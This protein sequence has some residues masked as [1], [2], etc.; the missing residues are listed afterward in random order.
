VHLT[1]YVIKSSSTCAIHN[2]CVQ[3]I[4]VHVFETTMHCVRLIFK[5]YNISN[6]IFDY[7]HKISNSISNKRMLNPVASW[8]GNIVFNI[9]WLPCHHI[10]NINQ[11]TTC[12]HQYTLFALLPDIVVTTSTV[13]ETTPRTT[14]STAAIETKVKYAANI[15]LPPEPIPDN[16][17]CHTRLSRYRTKMRN[18]AFGTKRITSHILI[19]QHKPM[20]YIMQ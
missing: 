4:Y 17:L 7:M 16:I 12:L 1:C 18:K 20:D 9:V 3:N 13:I 19:L 2:Y 8:Q 6:S 5:S 10:C 15:G 14:L 11:K